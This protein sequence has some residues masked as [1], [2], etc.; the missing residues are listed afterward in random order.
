MANRKSK[1]GASEAVS[2]RPPE[3]ERYAKALNAT[4]RQFPPARFPATLARYALVFDMD[5]DWRDYAMKENKEGVRPPQI[6]ILA[7]PLIDKL[8]SADMIVQEFYGKGYKKYY[9][10]VSITEKRQKMVAELM[11]EFIRLRL[12]RRDDQGNDVKRDGAWMIFKQ[13]LAQLYERCSEGTLFSSCQQCQM[14]EFLLNDVDVRALGPQLIQKESCEPGNTPLMQLKKD[15][16]LVDYFYLH[17]TDKLDWLK[18]NWSETY[19]KR[20]PIED[21]REYF[22]E[23]VALFFAWMGYLLGTLWVPALTG[24]VVFVMGLTAYGSSGSFDSPYVPLFCI[25]TSVWSIVVASGWLKVE[26]TYQHQWE[27]LE[28]VDPPADRPE[29]VQN[30]RT[31]KRLN[32]LLEKE[33]YYPDPLWR[34]IALIST[35]LVMPVLVG[36]TLCVYVVVDL[37]AGAMGKSAAAAILGALLHGVAFL[38]ISFV[39]EE[40]LLDP[41]TAFENWQTEAQYRDAKLG[42]YAFFFLNAAFFPVVLWGFVWNK[43]GTV[44]G[45]DLTCPTPTCYDHLMTK[46]PVFFL[47]IYLGRYLVDFLKGMLHSAAASLSSSSATVMPAEDEDVESQRPPGFEDESKMPKFAQWE[48]TRRYLTKALDLGFFVLF[49]GVFPLLPLLLLCAQLVDVRFHARA[50][51]SGYQRLPYRCAKDLATVNQMVDIVVTMGIL[52]QCCVVAFASN[53]LTYY[54][55]GISI[56]GRILYGALLEHALLLLKIVWEATMTQVAQGDVVS[57]AR[58]KRNY[59]KKVILEELDKF[60]P[61]DDVVF[62]TSDDGEAF[63]G[64]N[65]KS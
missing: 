58:D 40:L 5:D 50:V 1:D 30:K 35:C 2:D 23:S 36:G 45:V 59:E 60:N 8:R 34:W 27:M 56:T 29:F 3:D 49:G 24:V 17:H 54:F 48:L 42:K 53:G 33:E 57:T 46:V 14:I 9:A 62:Y 65:K 52:V 4:S 55:P 64:S 32:E 13:H 7:F 47:T 39:F 44:A 10:L 41:L 31:Y 26:K 63:Y 21:I 18:R 28:Y 37:A 12:K 25:F 11:G 16:K 20:Q 61:S 43:V 38:G 6:A 15:E 19:T 51:L 22:G